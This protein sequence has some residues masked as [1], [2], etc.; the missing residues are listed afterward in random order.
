MS[1]VEVAV[2]SAADMARYV[3]NREE[4]LERARGTTCEA[5]AVELYADAEWWNDRVKGIPPVRRWL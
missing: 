5:L 4:A 2:M 1:P 3:R